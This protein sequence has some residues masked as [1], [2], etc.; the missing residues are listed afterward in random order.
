VARPQVLQSETRGMALWVAQ[1]RTSSPRS[2]R[3][4][5]GSAN[6][7]AIQWLLGLAGI[8]VRPCPRPCA[9]ATSRP[10]PRPAPAGSAR[11]PRCAEPGPSRSF[12]GRVP[13]AGQHPSADAHGWATPP[14]PVVLA[15]LAFQ[16]FVHLSGTKQRAVGRRLRVWLPAVTADQIQPVKSSDP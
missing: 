6:L 3:S 8:S 12:R 11:R 15:L 16:K 9:D 5:S 14:R 13:R 4:H 7:P 10:R 1:A 2:V